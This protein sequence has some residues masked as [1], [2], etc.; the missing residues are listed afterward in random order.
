M[1]IPTQQ[2]EL[3]GVRALAPGVRELVIRPRGEP[4]RFAPGQWISLHLPVGERQPLIR[5]YSLAAPPS[6]GGEL[7]LCT[8]LVSGGLGSTYLHGLAPGAELTLA[9]PFGSFVAPDPF[10]TD[11]VLVT[12]F[13]GV[14]PV[15]CILKHLFRE[16]IGGGPAATLVY[17][18]EHREHLI[19][20][21]ELAALAAR[22][23]RFR[24]YPTAFTGGGADGIDR[25][26]ELE[27]VTELY[28]WP[29]SRCGFQPMVS[30]L[31]ELVNPVRTFFVELGCGRKAVRCEHY[32]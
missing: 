2:A 11:L 10:A 18:A 9:G 13:T 19:Y 28:R 14:V 8:D 24:Y 6:P 20:H 25:R 1:S 31:R 27:I 4:V 15:R 26:S 23:P 30:G 3:L 29:W 5:A 21:Q 32:D 7:V 16:P 22:T 17:G 12:R